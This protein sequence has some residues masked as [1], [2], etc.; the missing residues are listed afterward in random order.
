L[1]HFQLVTT[2]GEALGA[3]ELSRPDWP[4]RLDHLPPRRRAEPPLVDNLPSDDPEKFAI[5]VVE[6]VS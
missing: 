4:A 2:E 1:P 3:I 5:L 6:E